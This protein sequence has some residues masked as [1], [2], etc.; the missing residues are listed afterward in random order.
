MCPKDQ[1]TRGYVHGGA[2]VAGDA[3]EVAG[4]GKVKA[5]DFSLCRVRATGR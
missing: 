2:M 1:K 3:A 5:E 4:T